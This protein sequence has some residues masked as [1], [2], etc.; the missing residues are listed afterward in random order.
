[1]YDNEA[2]PSR[3]QDGIMGGLR[4]QF[5]MQVLTFTPHALHR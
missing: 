3:V 2:T 5:G 1:M 4:V